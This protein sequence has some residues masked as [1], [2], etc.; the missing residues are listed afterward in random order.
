[1]TEPEVENGV[2]HVDGGKVVAVHH[3][4]EFV[5]GGV[6]E[7]GGMGAAGAAPYDGR[8]G[9][10]VP[11]CG[12]L[13]YARAFIGGGDVGDNGVEALGRRIGRGLVVLVRQYAC[14]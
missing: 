11:G 4:L 7:E 14:K 5:E 12:L 2:R 9:V 1:M 13:N 3:G 6:D 10:V 8:R